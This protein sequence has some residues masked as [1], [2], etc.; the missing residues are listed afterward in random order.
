MATSYIAGAILSFIGGPIVIFVTRAIRR[1]NDARI[2]PAVTGTVLASFTDASHDADR[3]LMFR[4]VIQYSYSVA[5]VEYRNDTIS[6][7]GVVRTSWR[8]PADRLVAEYPVGQPCRVLHNPA[9]PAESVLR[10]GAGAHYYVIA[11]VGYILA[12]VG[13]ILLLK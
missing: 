13:A 5:G 1:A 12:A 2:W 9:D 3:T 6:L 11:G 7:S 4:P 10:P 8:K